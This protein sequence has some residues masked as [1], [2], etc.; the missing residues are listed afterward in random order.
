MLGC[1]WRESVL[2]YTDPDE[3]PVTLA[4]LVHLDADGYPLIFKLVEVSGLTLEDWL[5][6]LFNTVL[7]PLLHYLYQYGTVFS[8]HGENTILVLKNNIPSRLAMKDFVDD[9]NISDQPLPELL[10]LS[11][12]LK[13]V[14]LTEPPEGLCQFI[15]A[16]LFICHHRYLSDLLDQH[17]CYPK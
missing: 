10:N 7:P 5:D 11:A 15:F 6:R 8:P 13:E 12:D 16:G 3:R 2:S 14:L 17:I 4:S 9:V 1:L